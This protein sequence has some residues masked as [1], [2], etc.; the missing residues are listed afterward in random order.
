VPDLTTTPELSAG[1]W[2]RLHELRL[3]GPHQAP[4]DEHSDA[5]VD[6]G[7]AVR[8]GALLAPTPQGRAANAAWARL[9]PGSEAEAVARSTYERFLA[10][11]GQLKELIHAWQT[12]AKRDGPMGV[13]EWDF[14]DRLKAIDEKAGPL[15]RRLGGAVE[16][17]GPYRPRLTAAVEQ[18]EEGERQ[19]FCGMRCDSYHVVWWQ[20]HEDL[21]AALGIARADD[22]NQ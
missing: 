7:Y 2:A 22:P 12:E 9:A 6:A 14:V 18:L 10:L 16:R 15:L 1:A 4:D 11:D 5:L 19:W 21:L 17:F 3:R 13:E 8:R 20:L